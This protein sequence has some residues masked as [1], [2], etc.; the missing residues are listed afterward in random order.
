MQQNDNV[1]E[2]CLILQ[3]RRFMSSEQ[4]LSPKKYAAKIGVD[5][6]IIVRAIDSGKIPQNC[7]S[8]DPKNNYKLIDVAKA[9]EAWGTAYMETRRKPNKR[10]QGN[11]IPQPVQSP[12][13]N[14]TVDIVAANSDMPV[15]GAKTSYNEADRQKKIYE[16]Q[17]LQL[18]LEEERGALIRIE[19]IK[20]VFYDQARIVRDSFI[21]LSDRVID[22]LYSA[23]NRNTAH[24][25]L[26]KEINN[27]LESFAKM[28]EYRHE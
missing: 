13:I 18:K 4:F 1:A 6:V 22:Q 27:V 7:I 15:L 14:T 5:Y 10:P 11:E 12:V 19:M 28:P 16:A 20:K 24:I 3:K 2:S 8:V 25:I 23:E 9:D 17:L 21:S 26:Q